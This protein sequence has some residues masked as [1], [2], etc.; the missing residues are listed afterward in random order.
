MLTQPHTK[1]EKVALWGVILKAKQTNPNENKT[2]HHNLVLRNSGLMK[3]GTFTNFSVLEF[4][5]LTVFRYS[6]YLSTQT[7]IT[8]GYN[9]FCAEGQEQLLLC[10]T[11]QISIGALA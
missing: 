1:R 8:V 2:K 7:S 10:G 6:L 5:A 4:A 11:L 9:S 3:A